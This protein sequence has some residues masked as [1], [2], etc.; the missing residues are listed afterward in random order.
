MG[1]G[2]CCGGGGV[3]VRSEDAG[4]LDGGRVGRGGEGGG[5]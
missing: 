4:V 2:G 3:S 5:C 1:G